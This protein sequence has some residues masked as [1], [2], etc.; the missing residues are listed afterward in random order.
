MND[1]KDTFLSV[2]GFY[3]HVNGRPESGF[4]SHLC[5]ESNRLPEPRKVDKC[6][7]PYSSS[8]SVPY[9]FLDSTGRPSST[10]AGSIDNLK[11][12][13]LNRIKRM[14]KRGKLRPAQVL[15]LDLLKSFIG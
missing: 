6:W 4:V 14:E 5:L 11:K 10:V 2:N 1:A 13:V 15:K 3:V 8:S 9:Y 7:G 12:D